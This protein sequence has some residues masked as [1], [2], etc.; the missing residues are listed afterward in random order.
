MIIT[1]QG[2]VESFYNIL[3]QGGFSAFFLG[4]EVKLIE[5]LISSVTLFAIDNFSK[6]S[7]EK[8]KHEIPEKTQ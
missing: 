3:N 7:K 2:T 1:S 8:I 6:A 4:A 5:I